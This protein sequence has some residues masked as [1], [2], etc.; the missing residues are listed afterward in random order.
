M[1]KKGV[2]D[3]G[4]WVSLLILVAVALVVGVILLQA[5][6]QNVGTTN[7]AITKANATLGVPVNGT[8]TYITDCRK[9]DDLVVWNATGDVEVPTSNYTQVDNVISNGALAVS[10]TPN[11]IVDYKV[12]TWT[13]DGTCY[14]LTY[15][16]NSGSRAIASLIVVMF[17]LALGVVALTPTLRSGILDALGR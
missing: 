5:S 17:A 6:A 16:D 8:A 11:A 7:T 9:V 15:D 12:G 3:T 13:Y 10:V 14:P 2:S 4:G 1:N